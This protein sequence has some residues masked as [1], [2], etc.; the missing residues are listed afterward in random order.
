MATCAKLHQYRD[1]ELI[2]I[3]QRSSMNGWRASDRA[4]QVTR[5][6]AATGRGRRGLKVEVHDRRFNITPGHRRRSSPAGSRPPAKLVASRLAAYGSG[7]VGSNDCV[8]A[9][10]SACRTR[11][12]RR[13]AAFAPTTL[14]GVIPGGSRRK[15]QR[16]P[17]R[18][19][20]IGADGVICAGRSLQ[21]Q[22]GRQAPAVVIAGERTIEMSAGCR[23][24]SLASLG[25]NGRRSFRQALR[26]R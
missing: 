1:A 25:R 2:R 15:R 24:L 12:R 16:R 23:A 6:S 4:Q 17:L 5:R 26:T 13:W 7:N 11:D 18:C 22:G 8:G 10:G 3:A 9:A 14:V 21:R 20:G 19:R